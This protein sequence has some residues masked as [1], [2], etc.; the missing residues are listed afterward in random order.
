MEIVGDETAEVLEV[1]VLSVVGVV[2]VIVAFRPPTELVT[3]PLDTA[4]ELLAL[5]VVVVVVLTVTVVVTVVV[6]AVPVVTLTVL[7]VVLKLLL[8]LVPGSGN[9]A[10]PLLG[11]P[12]PL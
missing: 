10:L 8:E 9:G 2:T 3:G 5:D 12:M 4:L 1:G 7:V 6:L 11:Y